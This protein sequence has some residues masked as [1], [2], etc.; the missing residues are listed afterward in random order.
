[1]L[2]KVSGQRNQRNQ[3]IPQWASYLRNNGVPQDE[4]FTGLHPLLGGETSENYSNST[5]VSAHDL[6]QVYE[7]NLS[8]F[9]PR[10]YQGHGTAFANQHSRP[11]MSDRNYRAFTL[12]FREHSGMVS[13]SFEGADHFDGNDLVN[14]LTNTNVRWKGKRGAAVLEMQSDIHK[15]LGRHMSNFRNHIAGYK[16]GSDARENIERLG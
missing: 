14:I 5:K 7:S 6:M 8:Q 9:V 11:Y 13:T 4:I 12:R 2:R 15:A 16:F 1:M 10:L 3:T